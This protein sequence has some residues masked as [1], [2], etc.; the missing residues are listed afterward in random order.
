MALMVKILP[1]LVIGKLV[2]YQLK[3]VLAIMAKQPTVVLQ[4]TPLQELQMQR[5]RQQRTLMGFRVYQGE[6]ISAHLVSTLGYVH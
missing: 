2:V 4:V 5:L 6:A 3:T 1:V